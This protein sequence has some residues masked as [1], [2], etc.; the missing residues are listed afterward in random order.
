MA[1]ALDK[2]V[3]FIQK[4]DKLFVGALDVAESVTKLKQC[5]SK[6]PK[7]RTPEDYECAGSSVAEITKAMGQEL[8]WVDPAMSGF[9]NKLVNIGNGISKVDSAAV[10]AYNTYLE[11]KGAMGNFKWPGSVSQVENSVK[12]LG[13][14]LSSLA[15]SLSSLTGAKASRFQAVCDRLVKDVTVFQNADPKK[16]PIGKAGAIMVAGIKKLVR[17]FLTSFYQ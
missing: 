13:T 11:L 17:Q 6:P 9:A 8:T 16:G 4:G 1:T 7:K 2:G 15:G 5:L 14:S 3:G 12:D 10:G